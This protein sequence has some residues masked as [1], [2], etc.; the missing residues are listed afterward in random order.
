MKNFLD[1]LDIEYFLDF[2]LY[3]EPYQSTSLNVT[4]NI[5]GDEVFNNCLSKNLKIQRKLDTL[6]P[7]KTSIDISG[8][9]YN[10]NS[11]A[12]IIIKKLSIDGFELHQRWTHLSKYNNDHNYT[13]P[14]NHLGFNGKWTFDIDKPFYQWKHIITG[15]GWLLTPN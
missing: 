7:V 6:S 8:K 12:A 1:L 13:N 15:Q 5:N 11:Q 14:T 2:E 3:L 10:N 4:I 9:D